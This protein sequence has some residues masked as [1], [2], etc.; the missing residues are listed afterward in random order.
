MKNTIIAG[1]IG[2]AVLWNGVICFS[3][4]DDKGKLKAQGSS[5]KTTSQKIGGGSQETMPAG[6]QSDAEVFTPAHTPGQGLNTA[7]G[8]KL[9][10]FAGG[11][12][13]TASVAT[14]EQKKVTFGRGGKATNKS[15]IE[16]ST[17]LAAGS[18]STIHLGTIM[19]EDVKIDGKVSNEAKIKNS[20]NIAVGEDSV[21]NMGS[22][23]VTG[24]AIGKGGV[25]SNKTTVEGSR[26]MA[27]G[28]SNTANM[29]AVNVT[30]AKV[31]GKVENK[32]QIDT[33]A[34]VAIGEDNTANMGTTNLRNSN[35][36]KAGSLLNTSD[37]R[38]SANIVIGVGNKT[39]AG[40]VQVE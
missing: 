13:T 15:T 2:L 10:E 37:T 12:K 23:T 33:A 31:D 30:N 21:A 26:N 17:G 18:G 35:V 39:H 8:S 1:V 32:S 20:E 6:N 38:K 28:K 3:A 9:K 34:N 4:A 40:A 22:V 7:H 25:V 36:G 5:E 14:V 16:N 11:I 19:I 27:M 24:G 29:G